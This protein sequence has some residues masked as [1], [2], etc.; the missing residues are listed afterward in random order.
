M[1]FRSIDNHR[2][3]IKVHLSNHFQDISVK[4]SHAARD[5][6]KAWKPETIQQLD[7]QMEPL[8]DFYLN[9]S[10]VHIIV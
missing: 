1:S 3:L 9:S 10:R 8:D 7:E 5:D 4:R 6:F 2:D